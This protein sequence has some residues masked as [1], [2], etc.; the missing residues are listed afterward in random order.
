MIFLAIKTSIQ[1]FGDFPAMMKPE[2]KPLTL[3]GKPMAAMALVSHAE[4]DEVLQG[5]QVKDLAEA[6]VHH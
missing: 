2:G 5:I 4:V 6:A 1:Y 3:P